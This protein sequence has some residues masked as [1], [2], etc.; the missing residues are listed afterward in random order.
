MRWPRSCS[1]HSLDLFAALIE[2]KPNAW[3]F[4]LALELPYSWVPY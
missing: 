4:G 3:P 2:H 1:E